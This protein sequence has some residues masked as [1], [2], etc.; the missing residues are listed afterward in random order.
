MFFFLSGIK[1]A[2]LL[3]RAEGIVSLVVCNPNKKDEK[4]EERSKT[5]KPEKKGTK[6][7][8]NYINL[9]RYDAARGKSDR[10]LGH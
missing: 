6:K 10:K 8:Q 5:P 2:A 3:K 4:K 9:H 1:A 7:C